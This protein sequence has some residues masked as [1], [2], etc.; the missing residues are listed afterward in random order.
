[1]Q[2]DHSRRLR[3]HTPILAPILALTLTLAL[4]MLFSAPAAAKVVERIVAVVGNEIV[5]LSELEDRVRPMMRQ[6]NQIKDKTMRA[7]RLDEVRRQ[8]LDMMIDEKLI[9]LQ[10]TRLKL[11]VEDKDLERAVA[12]V[13]SKNNLTR[14]E[15][16]EALAQ[17]GKTITGYK[18]QIL[19]PQ[20]MRL[21][22]LNVAVRSRVS[23]SQDEIKALYQQNLRKLGVETKVRARHIFVTVPEGADAAETAK[24]KAR[25]VELLRRVKAK[26]A[27]FAAIAKETS[28]DPVT[29]EDG[30]DL[31]YF[32]RGTLPSNIEEVVFALKKGEIRGPLRTERGFHIVKLEDRKESSARSLDEVKG[33]LRQTL[34][35]QKMENATKSW[36]GELRK[37]THIDLRL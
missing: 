11:N 4:L 13:M 14:K 10:G 12:D 37:K 9:A 22:V 5:L 21:R 3:A 36:L 28:D 18:Q 23:V 1:M 7:Q 17:E 15:L 29:K 32:G 16:E 27:D 35:G 8:M 20:L 25:A 6:L 24:R 30:G 33:Q 19:K 26:G 2:A 34:Y 31:R